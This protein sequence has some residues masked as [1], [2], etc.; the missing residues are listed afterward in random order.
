MTPLTCQALYPC[1]NTDDCQIR[2]SSFSVHTP[3][4]VRRRFLLKESGCICR[5][6]EQIYEPGLNQPYRSTDHEMVSDCHVYTRNRINDRRGVWHWEGFWRD[7]IQCRNRSP[8]SRCSVH[9]VVAVGKASVER[10]KP[11]PSM[12]HLRRP[13]A[14]KTDASDGSQALLAL[15]A[16]TRCSRTGSDLKF[17]LLGLNGGQEDDRMLLRQRLRKKSN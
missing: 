1:Q 5:V 14:G 12:K 13:R 8:A 2:Y 10:S 9:T 17:G 6:P 3:N 15:A 16:R 11:A 4:Q 7:P